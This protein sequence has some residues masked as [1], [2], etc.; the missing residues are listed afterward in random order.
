MWYLQNIVPVA[1]K[2]FSLGSALPPV[3]ASIAANTAP[4]MR[5]GVILACTC[6]QPLQLLETS[7]LPSGR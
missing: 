2:N 7:E 4:V 3:K 5:A 6:K 1:I